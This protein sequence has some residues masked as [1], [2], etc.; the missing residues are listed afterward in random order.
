M[1]CVGNCLCYV[2]VGKTERFACTH[3]ESNFCYFDARNRWRNCRS[4]L[5]ANV[6]FLNKSSHINITHTHTQMCWIWVCEGRTGLVLMTRNVIDAQLITEGSTTPRHAP[7]SKRASNNCYFYYFD[8]IFVNKNIKLWHEHHRCQDTA[9]WRRSHTTRYSWSWA[10]FHI[11][12]QW[13]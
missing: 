9:R 1:M 2:V 11:I 10:T 13:K 5:L 6:I 4:G 3:F 12:F 8:H 7:T